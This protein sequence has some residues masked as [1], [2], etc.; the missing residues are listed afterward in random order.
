ML[1]KRCS[2]I[3]SA[4]AQA[5][6]DWKMLG[7][8]AK[9]EKKKSSTLNVKLKWHYMIRAHRQCYPDHRLRVP[10]QSVAIFI[11]LS[12][13]E[14]PKTEMLYVYIVCVH[15]Q[16]HDVVECKYLPFSTK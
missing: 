12:L 9:K 2:G 3:R 16:N 7:L 1:G 8:S 11:F 13:I 10:F 4:P 14:P 6:D 15:I 5:A